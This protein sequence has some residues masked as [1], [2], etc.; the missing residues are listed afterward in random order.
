MPGW[1]PLLPWKVVAPTLL[2]MLAFGRVVP[3]Y[4]GEKLHNGCQSLA[5]SRA[6]CEELDQGF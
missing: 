1:R 2:G 6:L 5:K 4:N 3:T